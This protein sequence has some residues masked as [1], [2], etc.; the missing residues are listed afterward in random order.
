M[1]FKVLIFS[2]IAVA[3]VFVATSQATEWFESDHAY[4]VYR[5]FDNLDTYARRKCDE[6]QPPLTPQECL[7]KIKIASRFPLLFSSFG[8]ATGMVTHLSKLKKCNKGVIRQIYDLI[9]AEPH[10][11]PMFSRRKRSSY[12]QALVDTVGRA[13]DLCV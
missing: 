9:Q 13:S 12:E 8:L 10:G 1:M 5:G 4:R 11:E 7:E 2:S 6:V 3:V